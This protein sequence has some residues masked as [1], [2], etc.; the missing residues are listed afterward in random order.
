MPQ[1][2]EL[3]L[4]SPELPETVAACVRCGAPLAPEYRRCPVCGTWAGTSRPSPF[5]I[6]WWMAYGAVYAALLL[7]ALTV[8]VIRNS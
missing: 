3:L 5:T 6:G 2:G 7:M 8:T 4:A 1:N